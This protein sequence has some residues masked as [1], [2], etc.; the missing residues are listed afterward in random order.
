MKNL[1]LWIVIFTIGYNWNYIKDYTIK[2]LKHIDHVQYCHDLYQG[3]FEY[4][5]YYKSD[6]VN[7]NK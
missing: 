3:R 6:I 1:I 7:Y 5:P 2:E 4:C